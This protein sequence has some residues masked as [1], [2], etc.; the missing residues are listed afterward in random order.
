MKRNHIVLF[1]I[2]ILLATNVVQ[3]ESKVLFRLDLQKGTVYEMTTLTNNSINQEMMGQK[4]KI[5]QEMEMVLSYHVL[6]VLP[7]KNF[8][9]EYSVLKMKVNMIVNGQETKLNSES[10]DANDP[11]INAVKSIPKLKLEINPKG[12]VEKVEGFEV[13]NLTQ[14]PRMSQ[15]L[16]MF[17][18]D[19][20]FKTFI[21]QMFNYFPDNEV[22]KGDK[23][24][25]S[26]QMPSM[27]NMETTMNYEVAD[28]SNGQIALFVL[29]NVDIA[30]PIEQ[31]GMK[32]DMKMTGT[33]TGNMLI[34]L[35][36]GIVR[37][38][39]INQKFDVNMK[40]KNPQS[41]ED[42]EIPMN[43]FSVVKITGIRK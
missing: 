20:S 28:I 27:M 10:S 25:S 34:D 19:K 30:T 41:G 35:E 13:K 43:V 29:S 7:N 16:E 5:D 4:I 42:M 39:E 17:M 18:N 23:W 8:M 15:F 31:A 26:F 9:I 11:M 40:M 37:S 24:T 3:A 33:Q 32:V 2:T 36:D 38:S 21:G 14:D 1:I 12:L 6:D 22:E